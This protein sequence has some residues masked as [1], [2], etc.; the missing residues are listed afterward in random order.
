[1]RLSSLGEFGLI[2]L[3]SRDLVASRPEVIKGIGDDA[4]VLQVGQDKWLLFT[5]DMLVEGVHF[6]FAYATPEQVGLKAVVASV[7]DIAAMG[8][9]PMHA[10]ISLGVP[11]HIPVEALEG[12]YA[13]VRRAAREYGVDI[14][15]GDTVKSP[16]RL[17]V[18]VAL[19][20]EV[21]AGRAIYRNGARPGDLLFVTGTLGNAAAGLYLC[22][23]P[24]VPVCPETR[25]FL[26]R[27][28]L[29]PRAR[30]GAGRVLAK[31]GKVTALDDIS[32]GLA[33]ELHEICRASGVGCRIS[34]PALPVDF[35]MKKAAEMAGR[36]PLDW[37]LYGGEDFELV[38]TAPRESAA[39]IQKEMAAHNEECYLIG[40]I[41]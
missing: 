5:A 24:E 25:D 26:R 36:D 4:A 8:G 33:S 7:S 9:W 27:A 19:L 29:E 18:N 40:E 22:A 20:G 10:L 38:F 2:E 30:V 41:L 17:V 37:A 21:E 14:V 12:I 32:D 3:L 23:H 6:S 11:L 34:K 31:T 16:E 1:M 39:L 13:G 28:H 15:G 35:R